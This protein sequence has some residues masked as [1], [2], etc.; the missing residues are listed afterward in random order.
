MIQNATI[1]RIDLLSGI[2]GGVPTF[3]TGA[4][5]A[6]RCCIS[7]PSSSQLYQMGSKIRGAEMVA[8]VYRADLIAAG[9]T[10]EPSPGTRIVAVQDE[11][12]AGTWELVTV[13]DWTHGSQSH[14]EMYVKRVVS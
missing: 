2:S 8:Y 3:T 11:R 14:V 4:T 10:G 9:I 13:R 7:N 1:T 5:V 6:M 12:T